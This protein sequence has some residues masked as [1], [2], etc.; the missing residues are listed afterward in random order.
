MQI[1]QIIE[2]LKSPENILSVPDQEEVIDYCTMWIHTLEEEMMELDFKCDTKLAQLIENNSVAKAE[3]L[4]KLEDVYKE[5]KKKDLT[6]KSLKSYRQNIRRK[7][8]RI[9]PR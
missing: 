4:L 9:I 2:L 7:R 6:L 5:R 1:D 8:D 3:V